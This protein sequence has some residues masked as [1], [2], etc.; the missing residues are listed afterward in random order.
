[1]SSQ[2]PS[3]LPVDYAGRAV[4][5][6]VL[7]AVPLQCAVYHIVNPNTSASWG[8]ILDGL[9]YAGMKFNRLEP[10]QW[11]ERLA[12]SDQDGE[13]NPTIKLLVCAHHVYNMISSNCCLPVAILPYAI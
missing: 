13:K 12:H 6:I 4:A 1:M 3:W 2:N 8:D 10:L 7:A 5:E 9:E 11:V